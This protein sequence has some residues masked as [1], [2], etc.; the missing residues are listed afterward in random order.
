MWCIVVYTCTCV[1]Y[2][3]VHMYVCGIHGYVVWV[4]VCGVFDMCEY[5]AHMFSCSHVLMPSCPM[6]SCPHVLMLPCSHAPM[7]SCPHVLMLPCSHA[8][9]VC[10]SSHSLHTIW[11]CSSYSF[12]SL[13]LHFILPTRHA[14]PYPSR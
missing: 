10:S 14:S 7:F 6:F 5:R 2:S 11:S 8:L 4:V 3:S 13:I 9:L 12:L 1:V